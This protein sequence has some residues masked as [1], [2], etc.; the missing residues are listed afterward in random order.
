MVKVCHI[1]VAAGSGS[2]FGSSLPK[3]FCEF[4]DGRPVLMTTIDRLAATATGEIVLVLSEGM[5]PLW[6]EMCVEH[7]FT[8]PRVVNGGATRWESVRNALGTVGDDVDVV[9]VHDGA[10]PL[11][12]R[13]VVANVLGPMTDDESI[14]GTIPVVD[15]TDSLREDCDGGHRAVDRSRYRAVQTPQAFRADRLRTAYRLPYET[16]FTDD[17]SV[18]EAAGFKRLKLV[19]GSSRNIKI[20]RPED[21]EIARVLYMTEQR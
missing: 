8:S 19:G 2:R 3:Q 16:T 5:V 4:A 17:A 7:G 15:V 9:T 14:D 13:E 20:T 21:L 18:M 12:S 1:V 10:R 11:V 6:R